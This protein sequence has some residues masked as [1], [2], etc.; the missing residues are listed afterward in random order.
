MRRASGFTLLELIIVI[1]LMGLMMGGAVMAIG[2]VTGSKA[3]ASATELAGTIRLLYDSA[4]LTGK[5]CRLVFELPGPKDD[6]TPVKYHAECAKFGL[7]ARAD[8]EAE[9]KELK[10][11][12]RDRE[13]K[14][15]R[16]AEDTRFRSLS[17]DGAPTVQELMAREKQRVEDDAKFDAF[18]SEEITEHTLPDAVRITVWTRHQREPVKS[19]TA[20]MY[21]FPQGFTERAQ[22]GVKQGNNTWTLVVQPLT[23]KVSVVAEELEVPRS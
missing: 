11:G 16:A 9:L 15:R 19:G 17:S 7:T 6:D 10:D 4:A 3:K 12:E 22:L 14:K 13:E 21:F 18:T 8:R 1:A 5:T 23:G 2:A 20:Y